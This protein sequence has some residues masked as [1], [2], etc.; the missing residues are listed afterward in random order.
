MTDYQLREIA[1]KHCTFP[2]QQDQEAF[3]T[4][5]DILS[6]LREA[7]AAERE[8]NERLRQDARCLRGLLSRAL[9]CDDGSW[10]RDLIRDIKAALAGEGKQ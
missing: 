6:A 8:E 7:V 4:W 1:R 3:W 2:E 5:P 9:F 10:G